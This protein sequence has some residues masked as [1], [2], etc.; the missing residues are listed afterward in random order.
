MKTYL[1][2]LFLLPLVITHPVEE[3]K[4]IVIGATLGVSTAAI[5]WAASQ[6]ALNAAKSLKEPF[7]P[8]YSHSLYKREDTPFPNDDKRQLMKKKHCL[9]LI[10][11]Q[12]YFG[13][14]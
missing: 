13:M 1:I 7:T 14:L 11:S 6:A 3:K 4:A 12:Y 10:L 5:S 8:P 9:L 2:V